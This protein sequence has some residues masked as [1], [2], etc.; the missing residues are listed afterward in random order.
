MDQRYPEAFAVEVET[1]EGVAVLVLRGELD[2]AAQSRFAEALASVEGG[3]ARIV[4]DLAELTFVNAAGIGLIR[5]AM[6][7]ARL[8]G[9]E[10]VLASP[11]PHVK[12]IL[13]LAGVTTGSAG[14]EPRPIVLPLPSR[15]YERVAH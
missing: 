14:T 11:N 12:R 13:E 2:V 15:A 9:A 1:S 6:K 4:L 3:F 8:R 7:L 10:F 5:G